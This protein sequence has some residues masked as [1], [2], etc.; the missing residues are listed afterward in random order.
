M[1][2][3]ANVR[4]EAGEPWRRFF[5]GQGLELTV[6]YE[7][8]KQERPIGFQLCYDTDGAE[9]ALTWME[10]QKASHTYVQNSK[11]YAASILRVNGEINLKLVRERYAAELSTLE[12]P[13]GACIEDVLSGLESRGYST[14]PLFP[15]DYSGG[16][17]PKD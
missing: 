17:L 16:G 2:E 11:F 6:W 1:R 7:S 3:I 5:Q 4:Q 13:I 15:G 9:H 12:K 14:R 8:A 10:G